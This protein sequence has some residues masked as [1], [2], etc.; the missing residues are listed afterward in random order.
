MFVISVP[1]RD[2]SFVNISFAIDVGVE[3]TLEA[4]NSMLR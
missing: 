3:A 2:N 4:S 1:E